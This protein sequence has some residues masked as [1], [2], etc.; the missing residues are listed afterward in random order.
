M[1]IFTIM[2]RD[3]AKYYGLP[4]VEKIKN[5]YPNS[6]IDTL[7]YKISTYNLIK[8]RKDLFN[9]VW[10]GYKYDDNIYDEN[11]KKE[12]EKISIKEIE[13]TLQIESVWK[14]LIHVDRSII[15]TP[16]KKFRYSF[17]YWSFKGFC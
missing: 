6:I 12:L 13:S 7:A 4:L 17:R 1:K 5:E 3:W 11:I 8:K 10:L 14:N 2:Q 16:G 15:Y 9:K